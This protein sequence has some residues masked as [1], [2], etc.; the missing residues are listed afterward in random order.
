MKLDARNF[1]KYLKWIELL[2]IRNKG[3]GAKI[4]NWFRRW[5]NKQ[6]FNRLLKNWFPSQNGYVYFKFIENILEPFWKVLTAI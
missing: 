3:E 4:I 6:I 1:A 2:Q 5:R